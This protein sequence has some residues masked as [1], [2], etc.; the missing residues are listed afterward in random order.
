MA[1]ALAAAALAQV[2][3]GAIAFCHGHFADALTVY[4]AALWLASASLFRHSA[5]DFASPSGG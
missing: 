4:F 1:A 2:A 3:A 5:R